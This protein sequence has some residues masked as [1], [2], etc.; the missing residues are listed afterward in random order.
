L[1]AMV[2][3]SVASMGAGAAL[4]GFLGG[5]ALAVEGGELVVGGIGVAR[6]TAAVAGFLTEVA[7]FTH[8]PRH[9]N[10]AR[11]SR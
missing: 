2:I 4:S 1:I 3:I 9:L 11:R 7:T 5:T 10:S 6:N 8:R